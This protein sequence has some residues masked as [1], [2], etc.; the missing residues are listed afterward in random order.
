[1]PRAALLDWL[2]SPSQRGIRFAQPFGDWHFHSYEDLAGASRRVAWG[3]HEAGVGEGEIVAV[4]LRS[5]P[6]FVA[7]HSGTRLA[8][9]LPPPVPPPA[10]FHDAAVSRERAPPLPAAR[11]PSHAIAE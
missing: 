9:A 1:M 3:L 11:Q 10:P 6:E 8:G 4:A 7:A 2:D 5:G